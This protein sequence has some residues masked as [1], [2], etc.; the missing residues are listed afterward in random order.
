MRNTPH[1]SWGWVACSSGFGEHGL[2]KRNCHIWQH[3]LRENLKRL[4]GVDPYPVQ[5]H[6]RQTGQACHPAKAEWEYCCRAGTTTK[7]SFGD[8]AQKPGDVT[9]KAT[10]LGEYGWHTG[11]AAGNDPPVG[12]LKPNPWG[13]YDMHGYL[14]EFTADGWNPD[15]KQA[16]QDG[17]AAK[18]SDEGGAADGTHQSWRLWSTLRM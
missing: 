5:D 12:A 2:N 18:G 7:Y 13:L 1:A 10:L 9:P 17:T 14:W 11:N 8:E 6:A 16:P 3:S 15:Y 4:R